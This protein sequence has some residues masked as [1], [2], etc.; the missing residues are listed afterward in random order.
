MFDSTAIMNL[1]YAIYINVYISI[2][3]INFPDDLADAI[4]I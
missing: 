2:D 1:M 3:G 4:A